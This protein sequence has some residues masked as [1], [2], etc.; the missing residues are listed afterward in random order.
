MKG[1]M[2]IVHID[3]IAVV[4]VVVVIHLNGYRVV[5]E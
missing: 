4:V 5:Y 3:A 2:Y 1:F